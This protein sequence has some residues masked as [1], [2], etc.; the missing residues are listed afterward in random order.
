METITKILDIDDIVSGYNV[1]ARSRKEMNTKAVTPNTYV[2][3]ISGV[4]K[5]KDKFKNW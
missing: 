2:K 1:T 4:S 3:Y 5:R